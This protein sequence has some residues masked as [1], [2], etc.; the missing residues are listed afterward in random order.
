ME[1]EKATPSEKKA[2]LEAIRAQFKG[3]DTNTQCARLLEAL[4]GFP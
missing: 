1:K 4:A 3:T 2:A